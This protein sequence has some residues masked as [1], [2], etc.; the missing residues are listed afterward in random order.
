[1]NQHTG[2][3]HFDPRLALGQAFYDRIV[4]AR[5]HT[6]LA[7]RRKLHARQLDTTEQRVVGGDL[8]RLESR[9]QRSYVSLG[10][11]I[12]VLGTGVTIVS[13]IELATAHNPVAQIEASLGI[14]RYIPAV[15]T[16]RTA[17]ETQHVIVE[18]SRRAATGE[19]AGF[20]LR[21]TKRLSR[22]HQ[23]H[24]IDA[25]SQPHHRRRE[26]SEEVM[27][28]VIDSVAFTNDFT[29]LHQAGFLQQPWGK[30]Q[31]AL[32]VEPRIHQPERV[33]ID[34]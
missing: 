12:K 26:G 28:S 24:F 14:S 1:M 10:V 18:Q 19:T 16:A 21:L 2:L 4:T 15:P 6:R 22:Y 11:G 29:R 31:L 20:P 7:V 8:P 13:D 34:P 27:A 30:T 23:C 17:V 32:R 9:L 33:A 25:R 3:A 5:G